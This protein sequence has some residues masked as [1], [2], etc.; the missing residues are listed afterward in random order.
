MEE[1]R[2]K[3]WLDAYGQAWETSDADSAAKLFTEEGI[4]AWGP[5][6]E[7]IRGLRAIREAWANATQSRQKDIR[8]GYEILGFTEDGRGIA[9]WWASMLALPSRTPTKMEGI[10]L[11]TL[12][13]DGRC[14]EFR[15]W[16]NED[17]VATG[18][19]EYQSAT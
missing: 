17:P 1:Q 9:R 11:V 14:A 18:A 19:S 13:D 16:W 3:A 5:F 6:H 7:P 12:A 2:F 10:F 8:F 4:Y 15:E